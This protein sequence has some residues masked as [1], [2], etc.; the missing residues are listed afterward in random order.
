MNKGFIPK[1]DPNFR[2]ITSYRP[3]QGVRNLF[4]DSRGQA[5]D[6]LGSVGAG[7]ETDPLLVGECDASIFRC[8]SPTVTIFGGGGSGATGRTVVDVF[9]QVMGVNVLNPGASYTTAPYVSIDD[10]CESGSGAV[11]FTRI[12]PQGQVTDVVITSPG[13]NYLGPNDLGGPTP[14]DVVRNVRGDISDN[15]TGGVTGGVSGG[16]DPCSVNPI[17]EDGN[18]VVGFIKEIIILSTGIGYTEDD[19]IIN[20][21]CDSDVIIKPKLDPDGRIVGVNIVNPGTGLKVS[22]RLSINT[23]DG[24]GATLLPVLGFKE[25][26]DPTP[27]TNRQIVQQ[28]ILCSEDHG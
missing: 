22:P 1:D 18:Q 14:E 24:F 9:G 19:I 25:V 20:D 15:V 28:V 8:G 13:L 23:Q 26:T 3:A 2:K 4:A 6:W 7:G 17:D 27:E 16:I 10:S 5:Q 12:N 21:V 11:G